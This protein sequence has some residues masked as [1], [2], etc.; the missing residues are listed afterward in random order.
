MESGVGEREK[1]ERR[2]ANDEGKVWKIGS[3]GEGGEKKEID[4]GR[5]QGGRGFFSIANIKYPTYFTTIINLLF[6]YFFPACRR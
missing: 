1:R 5:G 6:A 2:L 4:D 3:V